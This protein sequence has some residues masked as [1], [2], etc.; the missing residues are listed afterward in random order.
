MRL[1]W[2]LPVMT[3]INITNIAPSL[4]SFQGLA[5]FMT[6]VTGATQSVACLFHGAI[7]HELVMVIQPGKFGAAIGLW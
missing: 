3:M 1:P 6:V 2:R 4:V 7:G 5:C